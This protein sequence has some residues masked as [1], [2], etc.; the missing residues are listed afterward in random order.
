MAAA[1]VDTRQLIDQNPF[2]EY[3]IWIFAMC[4]AIAT[5]DGFDSIMIGAAVPGMMKNLKLTPVDVSWIF[6]LQ[7]L[8]VIAGAIVLGPLADRIG[9]KHLLIASTLIFGFFSL[10]IAFSTSFTEVAI[11]RCLSG[12][13]L[14][15][16]VPAAL[17]FGCEYA[18][19]RM[20]A[21]IT[22]GIWLALPLGGMLSGFVGIW[23]IPQYGWTILFLIG[24]IVPLIVAVL[25]YMLLPESLSYMSARGGDQAAMRRIAV[26]I[27]PELA[28]QPDAEFYSS[29]KKEPGVPVAHL[30]MEGRAVTTLLLWAVFFLSF[31]I[32]IFFVSWSPTLL[33]KLGA[34]Q[35]Q[36]SG[37]LVA[38]NIGSMLATLIIGRLID[39]TGYFRVLPWAFVVIALAVWATG[40]LMTQSYMVVAGMIAL[41]GFFVGGSNSGL[42]AL[43]ATSYPVSMRSTGVG[44]AYGVGGRTGAMAGPFLA[45]VLL[46]NGWS[47]SEICYVM[48]VPMLLGC[49]VL[50]VLKRV[51]DQ[52]GQAAA[53]PAATHPV[54]AE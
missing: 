54:P 14:G 29:E 32:M 53:A 50:L 36:A 43:A 3:Q 27:A 17:A 19:Q 12:V 10:M 15:G 11:Y 1:R 4:F 13:G 7:A 28:K 21:T 25:A 39:K 48:G 24:G 8:G 6:F 46:Q 45:G 44:W 22:T 47:A 9:R 5:I 30:F 42:M 37:T 34:T 49:V 26:R 41:V 23:L 33:T 52:R 38:W 51:T 35:Q 31:F 18:P 16:A 20:R 2:S 40:A